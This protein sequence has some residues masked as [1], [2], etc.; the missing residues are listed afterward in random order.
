MERWRIEFVRIWKRQKSHQKTDNVGR[1][2][3]GGALAV[4]I[5]DDDDDDD[6]DGNDDDDDE[7]D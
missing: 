4:G 3:C 5:N 1:I 6:D 2:V 7:D